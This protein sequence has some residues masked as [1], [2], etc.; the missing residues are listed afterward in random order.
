MKEENTKEII[1]SHKTK[2]TRWYNGQW[3]R[4][5]PKR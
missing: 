3:K 4:K 1:R 2:K 5:I